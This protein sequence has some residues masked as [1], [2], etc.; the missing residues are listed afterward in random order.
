VATR[1]GVDVGGTFTDL[2]A[3]DERSGDVVVVK[4]LTTSEA[5][6][7]GVLG[8]IDAGVPG[9]LVNDAAYF[10]HGTTVGLNALLESSG[11]V[12]GLMCTAGFRDVL[13]VRRG[14]RD[15][16]YDLLWKPPPPL[17]P[18]RLRLPVRGRMM[19]DGSARTPLSHDDVAAAAAAF[20]AE[21]VTAV[22]VVFINAYANPAHELEAERVLREGGFTGEV[23]LS[24]RVSGE[25][26]EYERT[27]TT[28]VDAF[29]RH[30]MG[31]YLERLEIGLVRLGFTGEAL[32]TRSGGGSL[33]IREAAERPFETIMSGP[34]AGA[35]GA[36]E[37]AEV[38]G[39][40][41]AVSADV[42]GTSF[43]TCLIH[44]GHPSLL[45]EGRVAGL[46]LQS[47]WVD[48]RSIGAG[49]GSIAYVDRGGLLRVGPR[50]AGA[51][52]GP[53]CY[54]LGGTAATVTDAALVLGML[55]DGLISGDLV[56]HEQ[57][58]VASLESLRGGLGFSSVDD[59][60]RGILRI[61]AASMADAIREITV[62]RGED[63]RGA[64][65]IAFGGAGPLF[66]T[67][68]AHELD[69][70]TIAVP[71]HAGSFSAWGL[72]GADVTR[73]AA[74]TRILRLDVDGAAQA[75]ALATE[76]FARLERT[77]GDGRRRGVS[78]DM[79]Y[80]GQEHSLTIAA[81]CDGRG[82]IVADADELRAIFGREY[83]R[84]FAHSM[85]EDAEIV[86]VR[87]STTAELPPRRAASGFG[88][89]A[90]TEERGVEAFS[91]E[92]GSRVPFRVL[93]RESLRLGQE[94]AGPALVT[95]P[96][97]ST[98]LDAGWSARAHQSGALVLERTGGPV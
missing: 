87:A 91:F 80:R 31:P 27:C 66:A 19:A 40:T 15:D 28:V 48:V 93:A 78:L 51:S 67:L 8:A 86:T 50:S 76:L 38:L 9:G 37:L 33:P 12:V 42:G 2:I 68:L 36:G 3:Y 41:L 10:L 57:L 71:K 23:S 47:P 92:R 20:S 79:R 54:G 63:V 11:A 22:A 43:D 55:G 39:A 30:R 94:L 7:V 53:A 4:A 70:A 34:V 69:V 72:L 81:P 84:T 75:D 77:G 24:H 65:L 5:P 97:T 29:V 58:A 89:A 83:E 14:D 49:G 64:T 62:E 25:Y 32:V 52:P 98:Y 1:I 26:R 82:R 6:E 73:T 44:E 18:R 59:V 85:D 16:P 45:Y 17:V 21:A 35:Q 13:E 61:A 95:E 56:L 88:V 96:T 90:P 60:A 74:R 46:P